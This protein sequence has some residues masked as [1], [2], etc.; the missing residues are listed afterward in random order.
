MELGYAELLFIGVKM[1][2]YFINSDDKTRLHIR[3]WGTQGK[4]LIILHGLAEHV[5]RYETVASIFQ[6]ADFKV[7]G[8]E[9]RGHGDSEG[10][11]GHINK[12]EEYHSDVNALIKHINEPY[13][14]VA[15][16]MGG[17]IACSM[18][19]KND[20]LRLPSKI[21]LSNPFLGFAKAPPKWQVK[22]VKALSK[23][24]PKT[25]IPNEIDPFL[26]THDKEIAQKYADD[27][28]VFKKISARWLTEV[29]LA[30]KLVLEK[31]P[32]Q[33]TD[34]LMVTSDQDKICDYNLS[35]QIIS[36]YANGKQLQLSGLYHE[37]FNEPSKENTINQIISWLKE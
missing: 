7:W 12:W 8:L 23:A 6:Q 9:L 26:L 16:S 27:P 21:V 4:N 25:Q 31:T 1:E 33:S 19:A 36:R 32:E 14:L 5:G 10:I 35:R 3:E 11:R 18:L 37:I 2:N 28:K 17:L 34:L 15:H 30:Q 13:Y 20:Y 22:M 29:L 24:F